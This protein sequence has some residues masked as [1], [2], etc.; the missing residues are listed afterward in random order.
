MAKN[1]LLPDDDSAD[2]S[3][4]PYDIKPLHE[5]WFLAAE[6]PITFDESPLPRAD[7]TVLINPRDWAA[8]EAELAGPLAAV[9]MLFGALD[10]R[11]RAAPSGWRHRLALLEA[12]ELSWWVGDRIGID[13]LALWDALRLAGVQNDSQA[14]GRMGWALRRLGGGATL[15]ISSSSLAAFLGRYGP[16]DAANDRV[17]DLM[18]LLRGAA[19]MHPITIAAIAFHGWRML[20]EGGQVTEIEAAVLAACLASG[21]GRGHPQGW[22]AVFMPIA[23]SGFATG[24]GGSVLDRLIRWLRGAERATLAALLHLERLSDWQINA[25]TTLA[26]LQGRTPPRLIQVLAEW[27][28]VTAPM[29]EAIT[30]ASRA[31][32]QRNLLLMQTRGLIREVTGQGRYRVWTAKF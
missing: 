16:S 20:G 31:S 25:E 32:V 15:Q 5:P 9:A 11:L 30:K 7:H 6:D 8:A 26:D 1:R 10:Q 27:P 2:P 22:G 13:R 18:D 12:A 29:A 23:I 28:M 24:S 3:D 17:E 4:G 19:H 14:L 21:M